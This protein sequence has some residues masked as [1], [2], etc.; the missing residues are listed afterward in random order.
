MNKKGWTEMAA[1]AV[2]FIVG[3][4]ALFFIINNLDTVPTTIIKGIPSCDS[5]IAQERYWAEWQNFT[6]CTGDGILSPQQVVECDV[7]DPSTICSCLSPEV[8]SGNPVH[9]VYCLNLDT[10]VC[11]YLIVDNDKIGVLE[12]QDKRTGEII[13]CL[14]FGSPSNN[15]ECQEILSGPCFRVD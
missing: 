2:T 10:D 9:G 1:L 12:L 5:E 14:P 15:E 3:G 13:S 4:F 8:P 11:N 7:P 6:G